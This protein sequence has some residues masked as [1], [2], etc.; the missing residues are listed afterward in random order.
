M[1]Y[2]CE[3][4]HGP[5]LAFSIRSTAQHTTYS[6]FTIPAPYN[7]YHNRTIAQ[8][9][10][11]HSWIWST[12][13]HA[14]DVKIS[15]ACDYFFATSQV[16]YSVWVALFRLF[17]GRFFILFPTGCFFLLFYGHYIWSMTN[18]LFD[19]GYHMKIN[20]TAGIVHLLVWVLW[21]FWGDGHEKQR[22]YRWKCLQFLGLLMLAALCEVFDFPPYFG[23]LDAHATWHGLTIFLVPLWYYFWCEDAK[24]EVTLNVNKESRKKID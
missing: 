9:Q 6:F 15:E 19:Y 8:S 24:Y 13:F 18:V 11:H 16:L 7:H 12:I 22:R 5:V 20:L 10:P 17:R 14:R 2:C 1:N 23:L 21:I 3:C 4:I